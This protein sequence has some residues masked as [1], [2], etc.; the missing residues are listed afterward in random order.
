[1]NVATD[2][3]CTLAG[4]GS[5]SYGGALTGVASPG[6]AGTTGSADGSTGEWKAEG[7]VL[8]SRTMGQEQWTQLGRYAI[9]GPSLVL[10][11]GGDKQL[12]ERQ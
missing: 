12:W 4:D 3:F 11:A 6:F 10:Y 1:M 8:F 5:F 7:G 2:I 9:S